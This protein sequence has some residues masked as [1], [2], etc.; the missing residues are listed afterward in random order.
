M[1][2]HE[3]LNRRSFLQGAAA[4]GALLG[5]G[6]R[7]GLTFGAE[8]TGRPKPGKIGDFKISLAEWS[9]HKSLFAKK[10]DNLDFPKVAREEFGIEGVEYVNQFFKDKAHDSVYLKDLK[11]RADD[12]GVT[13]VLIMIDGEGDLSAPD[14]AARGQAVENHKKWVDAA[15]ALGCH[16]I[17]VNTGNHYS[18]S[19]VADAAEACSALADYGVQHKIH[20]ICENHGGPSSDPDALLALIKAVNNPSFGTL[21]DFGNFPKADGKYKLDVYDAI[22]R[23]MPHAHGVSAKSYDFDEKGEESNLDFARIMKI[24]TDAGYKG[25]VGIEYEGSKLGEAEG[26]KAT[27]KLLESLRGSEYRG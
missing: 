22:A 11:K 10:L 27:K 8:V 2:R 13:N 21:P 23:M 9:L 24:V 15:A 3:S 4:G 26:I 6:L 16:A 17:R 25:W 18:K 14:K 1:S 12:H 19:D 5:L 7:G 20:V